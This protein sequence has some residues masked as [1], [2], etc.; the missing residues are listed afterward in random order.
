MITK[1]SNDGADRIVQREDLR[2]TAYLCQAGVWT[3]GIGHTSGVKPGMRI[4]RDTAFAL[5]HQDLEPICRELIATQEAGARMTQRQFDALAS[6]IMPIG[7]TAYR[8][9]TLRKRLIK[10]APESEIAEQMRRWVY[11]TD[12]RTG[13]KEKSQGL[14]N[15]RESEVAQYQEKA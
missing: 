2:L 6:F 5:L 4:T 1:I 15:R 11:Y 8:S 13:V 10:N 12:R 9:S 3:I 14:I 7:V